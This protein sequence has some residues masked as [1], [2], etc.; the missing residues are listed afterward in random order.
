MHFKCD[1]PLSFLLYNKP[2][3]LTDWDYLCWYIKFPKIENTY[4]TVKGGDWSGSFR[5][6]ATSKLHLLYLAK[7]YGGVE[8]GLY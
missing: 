1:S 5:I 7:Y 3:L 4:K 8:I 2:F 6:A